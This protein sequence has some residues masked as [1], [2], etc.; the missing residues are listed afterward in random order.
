ME[1]MGDLQKR[2]GGFADY[3]QTSSDKDDGKWHTR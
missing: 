3:R 1:T 2:K